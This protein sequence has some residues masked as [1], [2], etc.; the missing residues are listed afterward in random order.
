MSVTLD[1]LLTT[2]EAA[3][4]AGVSSTSIRTWLKAGLLQAQSTPLGALIAPQDLDQVLA[5]RDAARASTGAAAL[6]DR[7]ELTDARALTPEAAAAMAAAEAEAE[8]RR[9][10]ALRLTLSTSP[11][12]YRP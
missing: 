3:R 6:A 4:R 8:R 10:Y 5:A 2:S 11:T 1:T 12:D 9:E 7:P